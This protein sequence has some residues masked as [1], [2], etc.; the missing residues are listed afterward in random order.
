[1]GEPD[2]SEDRVTVAN[3]FAVAVARGKK[4]VDQPWLP[5]EF[6]RHTTERVGDVGIRKRQ[7]QNPKHRATSFEFSS[8][9]LQCGETHENDGQRPE[10]DHYVKRVVEKLEVIRPLILREIVQTVDETS[11]VA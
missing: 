6:G 11:E 9:I 8:P 3:Y 10:G 5:S 2:K 7:H 1:T 4:S